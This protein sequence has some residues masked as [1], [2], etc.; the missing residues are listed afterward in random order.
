MFH[1][2]RGERLIVVVDARSSLWGSPKTDERRRKFEILIRVFGLE[3]INEAHQGPT[4]ETRR[5]SFF[6]D[7]TLVSPKITSMCQLIGTWKVR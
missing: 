1:S 4:F 3:V 5:G 7:V 6:I 2:L